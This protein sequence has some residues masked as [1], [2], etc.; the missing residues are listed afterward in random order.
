MALEACQAGPARGGGAQA[1]IAR[2]VPVNTPMRAREILAEDYRTAERKFIQQGGDPERVK[3]QIAAYRQLLARNQITDTNQRQIDRWAQAGWAEFNRFVH[4]FEGHV[5]ATQVK[6]RKLVGNG[7]VLRETDDWF[8]V[9]PLD[10]ESSCFHGKHTDWCV[11]KPE[12]QHWEDYFHDAKV[13]LIYIIGKNGQGSYAVA[14]RLDQGP[15]LEIY[16]RED[17]QISS[18]DLRSRTGFSAD[19]LFRDAVTRHGDRISRAQVS[20]T[21]NVENWL[22]AGGDQRDGTIEREVVRAGNPGLAMR[23]LHRVVSKHGAQDWPDRLLELAFTMYVPSEVPDDVE[24]EDDWED[25]REVMRAS[26]GRMAI[27]VLKSLK[28]VPASV[29]KIIGSHASQLAVLVPNPNLELRMRASL[30]GNQDVFLHF[31]NKGLLDEQMIV[32]A[33]RRH[34]YRIRHV[35]D[36]TEDMQMAA[37]GSYFGAN[38]IDDI[39]RLLR[40]PSEKVLLKAIEISPYVI[41]NIENR[42]E[43]MALAIVK[44]QPNLVDMLGST[45]PALLTARVLRA[46]FT[47]SWVSSQ[48]LP[49]ARDGKVTIDIPP[50]AQKALAAS[51]WKDYTKY[52]REMVNRGYRTSMI[53]YHLPQIERLVT[54]PE[55]R[56][57]LGAL[58]KRYE[59]SSDGAG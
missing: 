6:R 25:P 34:P 7:I 49:G 10:K 37:I 59:V 14:G 58:R 40:N 16:D 30:S 21:E 50:V 9:I 46:A 42:T 53:K 54:D 15:T 31:L 27:E 20:P 26:Y 1:L 55:A 45:D 57:F 48:Y 3:Q 2:V 5:S 18:A 47:K 33:I 23:Y 51:F 32:A 17:K 56:R 12:H 29:Q 44:R 39:M 19:D 28:S 38:V 11:T 36:Q 52:G 24:D 41:K 8:V 13:I 4:G 22:K 43:D 35:K